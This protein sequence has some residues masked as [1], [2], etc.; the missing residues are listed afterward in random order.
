MKHMFAT[1]SVVLIVIGLLALP[2]SDII[3]TASPVIHRSFEPGH[4]DYPVPAY[5]QRLAGPIDAATPGC[6]VA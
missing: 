5:V 3:R 2:V 1:V 4:G 6:C